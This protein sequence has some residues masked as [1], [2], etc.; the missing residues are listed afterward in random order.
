MLT[1][2]ETRLEA[3]LPIDRLF[4]LSLQGGARVDISIDAGRTFFRDKTVRPMDIVSV[5]RVRDLETVASPS[6]CR[7]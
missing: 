6:A 3:D 4:A 1:R 7:Q 5:D 2:G